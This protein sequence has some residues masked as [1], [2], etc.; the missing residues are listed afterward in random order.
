MFVRAASRHG[1]RRRHSKYSGRWSVPVRRT[2]A[3]APGRDLRLHLRDHALQLLELLLE[4]GDEDLLL[5]RELLR[6]LA[7]LVPPASGEDTLGH[8]AFPRW[9]DEP[10]HCDA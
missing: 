1:A 10:M 6:E 9:A 4:L 8:F 7:R 3:L 2:L 5:L